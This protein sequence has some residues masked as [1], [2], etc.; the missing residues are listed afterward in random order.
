MGYYLEKPL[1]KKVR[2]KTEEEQEKDSIFCHFEAIEDSIT[3]TVMDYFCEDDKDIAKEV[4]SK[5]VES[6]IA[7]AERLKAILVEKNPTAKV[8]KDCGVDSGESK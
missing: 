3:K 5:G 8:A 2:K 4:L 7:E 1:F 6:I